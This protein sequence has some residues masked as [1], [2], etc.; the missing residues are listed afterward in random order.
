MFS[1]S[2]CIG[3]CKGE[4]GGEEE[5]HILQMSSSS[6]FCRREETHS[7][8]QTMFGVSQCP[9]YNPQRGKPKNGVETSCGVV[10]VTRRFVTR[11]V[12]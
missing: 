9:R 6:M 8:V 7:I 4:D 10:D 2:E 1:P 3:G 5:G 12:G 11:V